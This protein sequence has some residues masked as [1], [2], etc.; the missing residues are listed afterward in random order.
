MLRAAIVAAH[1]ENKDVYIAAED[2]HQC[3]W[4]FKRATA[5]LE[6][7]GLEFRP[8]QPTFMIKFP[9]N[10]HGPGGRISFRPPSTTMWEW[11]NGTHRAY[12]GA[13]NLAEFFADH[14]YCEQE[15]KRIAREIQRLNDRR[16]VLMG[17]RHRYDFKGGRK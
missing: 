10:G 5:L 17:H 2:R 16:S 4:I 11:E 15:I 9:D 6:E 8:I 3:R 7:M 1:D 13:S 12:Q 14:F